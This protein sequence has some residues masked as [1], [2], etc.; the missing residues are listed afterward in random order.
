MTDLLICWSV[1]ISVFVAGFTESNISEG[2]GMIFCR[3]IG[4]SEDDTTTVDDEEVWGSMKG[5]EEDDL[6][7]IAVKVVPDKLANWLGMIMLEDF[8]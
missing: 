6:S 3:T 4:S 8:T 5:A 2:V 7:S 1:L